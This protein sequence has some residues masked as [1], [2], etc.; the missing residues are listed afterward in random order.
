MVT[1]QE[2]SICMK[3]KRSQKNKR[4]IAQKRTHSAYFK[5]RSVLHSLWVFLLIAG[6]VVVSIY[7]ANTNPK[8]A[9]ALEAPA[10]KVWT[11]YFVDDFN[12]SSLD[13]SR[14][15]PYF[16]VYGDSNNEEACLTPSNVTVSGGSMKIT[17]KREY[18]ADCAPNHYG[19]A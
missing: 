13:T 15:R 7:T 11:P 9:D 14:W 1:Y 18:V 6:I 2:G 8:V 17:A 5:R 16:N 19:P 4:S 12:G 3:Q 10:G